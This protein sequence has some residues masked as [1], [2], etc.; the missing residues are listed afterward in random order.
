MFKNDTLH[1]SLNNERK[2]ARQFIIAAVMTLIVNAN[3]LFFIMHQ[4]DELPSAYW[5]QLAFIPLLLGFMVFHYFR[6][7]RKSLKRIKEDYSNEVLK[8]E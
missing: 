2:F 7:H 6:L 3:A 4:I 1:T 8:Q 5:I